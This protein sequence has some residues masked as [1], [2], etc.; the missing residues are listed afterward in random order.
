M[1]RP[2]PASNGRG[3][4]RAAPLNEE[5]K[6]TQQFL[7][8]GIP[9]AWIAYKQALEEFRVLM[10]GQ[11]LSHG[12]YSEMYLT[13]STFLVRFTANFASQA[14]HGTPISSEFVISFFRDHWRFGDPVI[15]PFPWDSEENSLWRQTH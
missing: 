5:E 3:D 10:I 1:D 14:D 7:A 15:L 11:R 6:E 9:F 2:S 13:T 8:D 4:A 12:M